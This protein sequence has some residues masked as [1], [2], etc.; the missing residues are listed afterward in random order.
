MA[1]ITLQP[2]ITSIS[3]RIGNMYFRTY[4]SGKTTMTTNQPRKRSTPCSEAEIQAKQLFAKRAAIVKNL[5]KQYPDKSL[6]DLWKIA[7]QMPS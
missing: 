6:K 5:R 2:F 4:A 1:K 7:K 3:G